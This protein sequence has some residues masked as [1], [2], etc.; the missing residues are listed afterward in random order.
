MGQSKLHS[1]IEQITNLTIGLL[2]SILVVQPVVFSYWNIQLNVA[3]NVT[4][5]GVFTV[6]SLLR[7]Y[8]VR[9]MFNWWHHRPIT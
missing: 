9:R 7:G 1:L 4:I 6:V 3:E 5:A 8:A 2:L